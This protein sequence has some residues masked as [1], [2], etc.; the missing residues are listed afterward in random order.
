VI[1]YNKRLIEVSVI[2]NHLNK[3]DYDKIPKEVI[4]RIEKNKD[5]EYNWY[6]DETKDLKDQKVSKDTIAILSYINMKYLL[7]EEQRK[8]VEEV[9]KENQK[10]IENIKREKYKPDNIFKNIKEPICKEEKNISSM[11]EVKKEKWY[12]KIFKLI[13]NLFKRK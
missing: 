7:N 9:F 1:E 2:L 4:D 12:Q 5:T 13:K 6:Y 11:I 8:F 3:S 10:K